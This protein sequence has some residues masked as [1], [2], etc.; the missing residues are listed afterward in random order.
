MRS[1]FQ[2]LFNLTKFDNAKTISLG[3]ILVICGK[4]LS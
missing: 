4:A 1:F 3:Q 2:N